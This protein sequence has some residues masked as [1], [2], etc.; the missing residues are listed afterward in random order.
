MIGNA[1]IANEIL[2]TINPVLPV[3]LLKDSRV[4]PDELVKGA[5]EE[6]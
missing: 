3:Q 5:S 4:V 2:K 1:R 6:D